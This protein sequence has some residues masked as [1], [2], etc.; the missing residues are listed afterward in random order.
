MSY[1]CLNKPSAEFVCL[2]G[3]E[4]NLSAACK[5]V[6]SS[7]RPGARIVDADAGFAWF[8][9]KL[10]D[11]DNVLVK[12]FVNDDGAVD[13]DGV[14]E[15]NAVFAALKLSEDDAKKAIAILDKLGAQAV[16]DPVISF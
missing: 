12:G 2:N 3:I 14:D 5:P 11:L 4:L 8:F 9:I 7:N 13:P 1:K 15:I 6:Y 10:G 16:K